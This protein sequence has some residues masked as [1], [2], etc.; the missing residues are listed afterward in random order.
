MVKC[1]RFYYLNNTNII[2]NNYNLFSENCWVKFIW[3]SVYYIYEVES[4]NIHISVIIKYSKTCT[5]NIFS[6]TIMSAYV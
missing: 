6:C 4:L 2:Q 3:T 5:K 1:T